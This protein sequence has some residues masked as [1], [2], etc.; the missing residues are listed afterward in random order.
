MEE[1]LKNMGISE[2][3]INS[4]A[5]MC[6]NIKELKSEEIV[7]KIKIL[8]KE[9]CDK[10]QIRNII[11]SNAMYLDRSNTDIEKLI[12]KLKEF[13]FEDL[14]LLFDGNPYILNLSDFEIERYIKEREK[15]GELLEDIVDD[16]RSNLFIFDE[17]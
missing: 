7:E 1:I 14:D 11:S 15:N 6:A 10:T 17:I 5:E 4:M 13:G 8:E 12:K 2:K 3:T 16:M 9:N